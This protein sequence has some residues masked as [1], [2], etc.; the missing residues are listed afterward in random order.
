METLRELIVELAPC[1]FVIVAIICL[2]KTLIWL[3]DHPL[4][5]KMVF[6]AIFIALVVVAVVF[7]GKIISFIYSAY[8][9]IVGNILLILLTIVAI[10][11]YK[12]FNRPVCDEDHR[13]YHTHCLYHYKKCSDTAHCFYNDGWGNG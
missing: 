3:L 10:I 5:S 9:W 7:F 11:I 12:I 8:A 13:K 6:S 4:I 1:A 2:F